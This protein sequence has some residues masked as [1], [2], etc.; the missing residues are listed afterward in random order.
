MVVKEEI[1]TGGLI[2][3][4][5]FKSGAVATD[6]KF[7]SDCRKVMNTFTKPDEL[8]LGRHRGSQEADAEEFV[9]D[10]E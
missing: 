6:S 9:I 1:S 4:F 5:A 3:D 10:G 8:Y 7:R 2:L